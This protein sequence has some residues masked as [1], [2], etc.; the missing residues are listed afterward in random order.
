MRLKME[1]LVVVVIELLIAI[2][3]EL[4]I[5]I[6]LLMAIEF[7]I[8]LLKV[9]LNWTHQCVSGRGRTFPS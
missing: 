3:I 6:E 5:V 2:A 4:L 7:V 1:F 9:I 8:E